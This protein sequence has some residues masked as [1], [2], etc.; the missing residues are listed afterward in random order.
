MVS[1]L[2]QP[3]KEEGGRPRDCNLS[4]TDRAENENL[5]PPI[6]MGTITI[7]EL[8]KSEFSDRVPASGDGW[9]G[10]CLNFPNYKMYLSELPSVF[11]KIATCICLSTAQSLA[12]L[13][14]VNSSGRKWKYGPSYMDGYNHNPRA[15]KQRFLDTVPASGERWPDLYW[16]YFSKLSNVF[17]QIDTYLSLHCPILGGTETGLQLKAAPRPTDPIPSSSSGGF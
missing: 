6:W 7:Q 4:T 8:A 17:V 16:K 12:E 13:K 10:L 15:G 5:D 1:L 9:S 3:R 11:V 2:A 14:Q